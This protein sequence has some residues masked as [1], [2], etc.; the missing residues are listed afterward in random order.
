MGCAP[1]PD[2][3]GGGPPSEVYRAVRDG[4]GPPPF[5]VADQER[6]IVA[7]PACPLP[8]LGPG[9]ARAVGLGP[10]AAA[11][12]LP[13]AGGASAGEVPDST[14][15]AW[16][17]PNGAAL[18]LSASRRAGLP[19]LHALEGGGPDGCRLTVGGRPMAVS[20]R[21]DRGG[22]RVVYAAAVTGFLDDT[23]DFYAGV[24]APSA[25]RRDSLLAAVGTLAA[26]AR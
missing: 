3:A 24:T 9:P 1:R 15:R 11:L 22:R 16:E 19:G 12:R 25:G 6:R 4:S 2:A 10:R 7:L 23:T 8:T 20:R 21:A 17:W 26:A 14:W 18:V 13:D 5:R